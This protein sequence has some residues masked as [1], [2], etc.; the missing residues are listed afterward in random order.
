MATQPLFDTLQLGST[1]EL[2]VSTTRPFQVLEGSV[3]TDTVDIQ[4]SI[5]GG[6]F[7]SDPALI[8]FEVDRFRIPNAQV[9]P[10]GLSLNYGTNTIQIRTVDLLGNV[11]QPST[12]SLN[13]LRPSEISLVS[14]PPSGL[15]VRRH[16]N[17][18]N[19][20]FLESQLPNVIGY[21][22]YASRES[23]GGSEGYYRINRDLIS[24]EAFIEEDL[25]DSIENSTFITNEFG[26]V[27]VDYTQTDFDQVPLDATNTRRLDTSLLGETLKVTTRVETFERL[28]YYNFDHDR[29]A[30]ED[31][32][33]INNEFFAGL[34]NQDPLFYV[35]TSVVFDPDT[36][37]EI[38][39]AYSSELMGFP[40]IL[41]T[42]PQEFARRTR[43]DVSE[44]YISKILDFDNEISV[45]PG[46]VSRD[47]FIDPFATEAERLYFLTDFISRSRSFSSLLRVDANEAYKLALASAFGINSA[48]EVQPII[49]DAFDKLA[50]D[51]G[52]TR[53]GEA[54][55]FGEAVFF[56]TQEPTQDLVV[57]AG[58]TVTTD[59]GVAFTV[60]AQTV[61]PFD[62]RISYFNQSRR[63]YEIVA[64]IQANIAGSIGNVIADQ[65][66]N[67]AGGGTSLQVTNLERTQFGRD[68]E[69]NESLAERALLAYSSV[70]TGTEP[71][72]LSTA[73]SQENVFRAHVESAG[74][75]LMAR[76][77]DEVR[78]KQIGGK[79]DV[80]VQGESL[81]TLTDRFALQFEVETDIPF[82]LDS[83]PS[84]L[85]FI[86]DDPRLTPETPISRIL[87][88]TP[89]EVS[90]GFGFRNLSTGSS[91]NLSGAVIL[92][93]NRIQ[94]N[95]QIAQPVA[96]PNHRFSGDY[97]FQ[98]SD[99][100]VLPTQPVVQI[101]RVV[102]SST[103][104]ALT[105][106]VNYKL[107]RVEDPLLNGSSTL[108]QDYLQ[109]ISANGIPTGDRQMVN[110]EEH[111]LIGS[112]PDALD[113]LGASELSVRVFNLDRSI[114]YT[115]PL[116]TTP[117]YF[118]TEGSATKA[119]TITRNPVGRIQNGQTVV[120]DYT[121]DENFTVE[122]VVND[123]IQQVQN[124]IETQRHLTADVIV[125]AAIP[126]PVQLELTVVLKSGASEAVVDALI[127]TSLSQLLNSLSI[128]ESVHQSDVI[129]AVE[130]VDGVAYVVVPLARMTHQDGNLILRED[131][132][133]S[134][135]FLEQSPLSKV[136]V[137]QD[138]LNYA[139]QSSTEDPV[140]PLAVYEDSQPI[141]LAKRYSSLLNLE[142]GSF[143]VGNEGLIIQGYSDDSTLVSQGFNTAEE[144]ETERLR[145]TANRVFVS[146]P[147]NDSPENHTYQCTYQV[148]GDLSTQSSIDVSPVAY[149]ELGEL[150]LT[151][152]IRS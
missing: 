113:N 29:N 22:I 43:F 118:L 33:V 63:R 95:N 120:V 45:I 9:F 127:R 130:S 145:L 60:T 23:G 58:T 8:S 12:A 86:A 94:L 142:N 93:F 62:Q 149:P 68:E 106:G 117:D 119:V 148:S 74:D 132:S 152:Q 38:E 80:W 47:I 34:S 20:A 101:N 87:G 27:Q 65:I 143:I 92:D 126:N 102:S 6:A 53:A 14:A 15:R 123:T 84:D 7:R 2:Q 81:T 32:G 124:A 41:D 115:G 42:Q 54:F 135:V 90:Q 30:T 75:P 28:T 11:S 79:V 98:E 44:D 31:D 70:D 21:N 100:F 108:A 13:L 24:E 37:Q 52:V 40:L 150:T 61:L 3:S 83:S 64:P 134:F 138:A 51:N 151:Y 137:L 109:I 114:E 144:R 10:E 122:Y 1:T 55:S 69:S 140:L 107:F 26:Q 19:I 71:G 16:F 121:H 17:R 48:T 36:N 136:Y 72:Y 116:G 35:I 46:S 25:T 91:F 78:D 103:G 67:V 4:I 146:L 139:T 97:R 77:Y 50:F 131:L 73:I 105:E 147:L 49:D 56:T 112:I 82:F 57:E 111:V 99:Q 66:R 59:S 128:G 96:S 85:I 76:D 18:V 39:S 129:Q 133:N 125:K 89:T 110:N 5:G 88:I 104:D 141:E